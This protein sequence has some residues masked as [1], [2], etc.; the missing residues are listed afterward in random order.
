MS[1]L[2]NSLSG[3]HYSILGLLFF[4]L[5]RAVR[6]AALSNQQLYL[7]GLNQM[8]EGVPDQCYSHLVEFLLVYSPSS[9]QRTQFQ[10][11]VIDVWKTYPSNLELYMESFCSLYIMIVKWDELA[12]ATSFFT[13]YVVPRIRHVFRK[14]IKHYLLINCFVRRVPLLLTIFTASSVW[15]RC[16]SLPLFIQTQLKKQEDT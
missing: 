3:D 14:F 9:L 16:D 1:D 13:T 5:T 11:L 4:L 6:S 15:S 7:Q 10:T 2:A 8:L 12:V